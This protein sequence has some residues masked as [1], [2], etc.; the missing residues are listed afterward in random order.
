MLLAGVERTDQRAKTRRSVVVMHIDPARIVGI[1]RIHFHF[2]READCRPRGGDPSSGSSPVSIA[3][4]AG[5]TG[6][7]VLE[8]RGN[9]RIL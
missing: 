4:A 2:S 3:G 8:L 9:G 1:R 5:V 7:N 6:S